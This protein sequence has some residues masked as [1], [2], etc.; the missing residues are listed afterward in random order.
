[1]DSARIT[2]HPILSI[3]LTIGS[4]NFTFNGKKLTGKSG[5]MISSALFANGIHIFGHHEKDNSPQG[6]FCAN[7]QCAQCLVIADGVPVKSCVTPIKEGMDVRS[8]K[9]FPTLLEDDKAVKKFGKIPTVETTVLIV[10]GGPAGMS[11]AIEFGKMRQKCIICDDKQDLG[12]KLGLQ[13][14]NFFGSIRDC[15]AGSRGMDI[16][17]NLAS[18]VDKDPN[19]EV[20]TNSPVVGVFVDR[21]VGIVNDGKYTFVKPEILLVTAGAREKTLGF[22]GCDLPGVYGAGAFQTLVNRDLIKPTDKLFVIGG[23]NVGLIGAYHALQA[24]VD[25][26]GIVEALPQCGGYKVHLDKIKRLGIP[27]YTSHTVL[28]AEGKNHLE[29]VIITEID[30]KFR[31]VKGT[32]S[33][34]EADTLLIAVGLTPVDELKKQAENFGF[35]TYAAGD[36]NVIAEA[37]AAMF[38]GRIIARRILIDM[39]YDVD[40]P[41]EWNDMLNILCSKP[42]SVKK[43][44]KPQTDKNVHP[45]IHCTQEIPCNPCTE[46]CVLQSIKIKDSSIMGIPQFEYDCLACNRCVSLCPGLAIT[47]VDRDY[48]MIKKTAR[49]VIPWELPEGIIKIGQKV[50]TTGLEGEPISKGKVIAIKDA[51]WQNRRMLMSLEVPYKDADK[52]AGIRIREPLGK[53]AATAVKAVEDGEVIICRC[54]RIT[55]KEVVDY[56]EKTGTRD[57]NAIKAALRVGMGACGGK[58]C[59]ELVMRIF[60]ELGIDLNEIEPFVERPFTQEVPMKAFLR[61]DEV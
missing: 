48:D 44:H 59:K 30:D 13:T 39:G 2:K 6:I 52:I 55:K 54:E 36:A 16:G 51:E 56:I 32:E 9:G 34:F 11:A 41:S 57:A 26:M 4:V 28:R 14:H 49:V 31:P 42:G 45:V 15:F 53:K 8:A 58:T 7:G 38:S 35:K 24:G 1:M 20:W 29:R 37:S 3:D 21:L 50:T 46:A 10:G 17:D 5:E 25:V 23:G 18:L 43:P 12:G 27:I 33:I 19:I 47:L 61:E 40:I 60:R 22:P